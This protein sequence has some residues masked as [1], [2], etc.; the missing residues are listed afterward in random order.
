M[1][2]LEFDL[3]KLY[4]VFA[5]GLWGNSEFVSGVVLGK[6]IDPIV[7]NNVIVEVYFDYKFYEKDEYG[8][9]ICQKFQHSGS[10]DENG[11]MNGKLDSDSVWGVDANNIMLVSHPKHQAI[12]D[13]FT[14]I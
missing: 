9:N 5:D 12:I 13:L 2:K 4:Y 10:Y 11:M 1:A 8:L 7:Y 14:R 3:E 6:H